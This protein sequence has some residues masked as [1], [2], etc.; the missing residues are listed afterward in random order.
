MGHNV[1]PTQRH[2]PQSRDK[3]NTERNTIGKVR[4]MREKRGNRPAK[5]HRRTEITPRRQAGDKGRRR[6][7]GLIRKP[8][9]ID[10]GPAKGYRPREA[11]P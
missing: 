10:Q 8:E 6:N 3:G 11:N 1:L 5:G 9:G 4:G 2:Y 7:P